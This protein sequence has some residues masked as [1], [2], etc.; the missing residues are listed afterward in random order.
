MFSVE[1]GQLAEVQLGLAGADVAVGVEQ[2]PA[3]QRLLVADVVVE[4]ALVGAGARGNAV[5]A[6]ALEAVLDELLSGRDQDVLLGAAG[7][8]RAAGG[9]GARRLG[10]HRFGV[11]QLGLP[12]GLG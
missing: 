2:H 10:R 7:V 3:V 6:R 8:A 9:R 11:V 5:D 12:A 1:R 4:H